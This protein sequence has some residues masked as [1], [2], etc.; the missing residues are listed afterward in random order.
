[1]EG[2][3]KQQKSC[4]GSSNPET[5]L[6][7]RPGQCI[8]SALK[9]AGIESSLNL[10]DDV[11]SFVR[12]HPLMENSV[13]AAPLVVRRGITYTKIAVTLMPVSGT[14]QNNGAVLHLGTD[15]G[16]LH[17]ILVRGDSVF[18]LQEIPLFNKPVTNILLHQDQVVVSSLLSVA[19]VLAEGVA[20]I[21]AVRPAPTDTAVCGERGPVCPSHP[22]VLRLKGR[23]HSGRARVQKVSHSTAPAAR[24]SPEVQVLQVRVGLRVVLPCVQ[25]SPSPCYW[26]HPPG[27]HTRLQHWD[28]AVTVTRETAGSYACFCQEG[29]AAG[30]EGRSQCGRAAYE[31]VLEDPSM[32]ASV[33]HARLRGSLA[34]YL[35]CL[36]L[37]LLFGA[38]LVIILRKQSPAPSPPQKDTPV[39]FS[40]V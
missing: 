8:T 12:D 33:G 7:P 20:C 17:R 19:C 22:G 30:G 4:D 14:D 40:S 29:G 37:G 21:P 9:A 15:T 31:L 18:L 24:C 28:L 39:G 3:F 13:V 34:L 1:M 32:G 11:L 10:P 16:E 25:V 6:K 36:F 26:T 2:S 35:V 5:P 27:R 38:F 23:S